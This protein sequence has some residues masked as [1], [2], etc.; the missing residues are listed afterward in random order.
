MV[1]R[2]RAREIALQVL[3]EEDLHPTR[4]HQ[5][6]KEFLAKRLHRHQPLVAFA[7]AIIDG[8]RQNLH[9]IDKLLTKHSANWAIKRMA[10]ID[11]NVLRIAAYEML[12]GDT[13]G[14]VAINEAID[15]AR[16]YGGLHSGAFVNG[17]LDR[18]LREEVAPQES[19]T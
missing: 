13:P 17:V 12:H 2:R 7:Q 4:D 6:A 5:V 3:F 19:E 1:T 15:I 18:I 11:R 9:Q 8:V 16:R 14:R 10:T